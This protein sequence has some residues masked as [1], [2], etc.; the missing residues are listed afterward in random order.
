M[1]CPV[2]AQNEGNYYTVKKTYLHLN[3]LTAV[4]NREPVENR[5]EAMEH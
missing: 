2:V 4:A 3:N 5:Q 1:E